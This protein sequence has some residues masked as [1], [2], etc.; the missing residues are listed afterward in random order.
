MAVQVIWIAHIAMVF[1][2]W[3][4][5]HVITIV[6]L[7]TISTI[8]FVCRVCLALNEGGDVNDALLLPPL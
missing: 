1:F 5:M 3:T 8:D 7:A 6:S 4:E 2:Y